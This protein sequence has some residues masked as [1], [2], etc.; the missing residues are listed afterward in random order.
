LNLGEDAFRSR[1]QHWH[2][3]C[4]VVGRHLTGVP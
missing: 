4:S 3:V 2:I 1:D